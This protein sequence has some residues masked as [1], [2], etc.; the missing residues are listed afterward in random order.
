MI[1]WLRLQ[2]GLWGEGTTAAGVQSNDAKAHFTLVRVG[3]DIGSTLNDE[4]IIAVRD[5]LKHL[6]PPPGLRVYASG[7]AVLSADMI[8]VGNTLKHK[9]RTA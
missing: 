8:Y 1:D 7:S 9:S 4:S 2:P 5:I 3:G 6:P